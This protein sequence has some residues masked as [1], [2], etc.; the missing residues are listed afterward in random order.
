MSWNRV[1]R[2][3]ELVHAVLDDIA[4][5]GQPVVPAR[6]RT[7]VDAEFGGFG[8]FLREVQRRWY[9]AFDARLDAVLEDRPPDTCAALVE[10]WHDLAGAMPTA[11]FLLDA[12]VDHPALAALHDRHRRALHAATGVHLAPVLIARRPP[13]P[14]KGRALTAARWPRC[15]HRLIESP[16]GGRR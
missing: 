11:R 15:V 2:R 1:H 5:S 3:H 13:A 12:H 9:R 16:P 8:E 4:D 6:W 14:P 10:L 7:E